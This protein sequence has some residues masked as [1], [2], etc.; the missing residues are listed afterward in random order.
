MENQKNTDIYHS[1]PFCERH[2][3]NHFKNIEF[4]QTP[5]AFNTLKIYFICKS[6]FRKAVERRKKLLWQVGRLFVGLKALQYV[7]R[8][9]VASMFTANCG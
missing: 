7:C 9:E 4:H 8:G 3:T 6:L 1:Q 5:L 2:G